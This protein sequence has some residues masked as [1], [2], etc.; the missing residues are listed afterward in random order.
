[1]HRL[2]HIDSMRGMAAIA[3]IYSHVAE[4]AM[5]HNLVKSHVEYFIFV[6]L[7]RF[8]SL[9][10]IAVTIFFAVSGFVIPFSIF[11]YRKKALLR[12]SIS[13]VFRLY[14]A[15]WL[16]IPFGLIV[17]F[18]FQHRPISTL[19]VVSN[20]TMLQ[21][22]FGLPDILGTYWTLQIELIFYFLCA[23]LFAS[24]RLAEV[25]TVVG[26][27]V[28]FLAAAVV[29]SGFRYFSGIR[30]PVALPLALGIMFGD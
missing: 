15:Y 28:L 3:V 14:P 13:R 25:R 5:A 7:T 8:M 19:L 18:G 4:Y 12:F 2:K 29:L 20:L 21:Q 30:L 10:K 26:A 23:L 9:G 11:K 6:L 27:I 17:L 1:M 24:N 16:S 22:F